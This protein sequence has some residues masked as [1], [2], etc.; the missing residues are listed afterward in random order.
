[1]TLS[2]TVHLKQKQKQKQEQQ[3]QRNTF[4]GRQQLKQKKY[5]KTTSTFIECEQ[6]KETRFHI[7]LPYVVENNTIALT[8][9]TSSFESQK[10]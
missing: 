5:N 4:Y 8:T 1:M 6:T 9:L 7:H 3:H 2:I 10:E